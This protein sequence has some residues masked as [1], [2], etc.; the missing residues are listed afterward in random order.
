MSSTEDRFPDT[1]RLPREATAAPACLMGAGEACALA[2]AVDWSQTSIGPVD[3]W[4]QA[5]RST[6]SLV[7][8]N[9]SPMLLWWGADFVQIYNDAY[10]PVLGEK[11]PRAMG[12]RFR[13]C[14]S[15]VFHILGPMAERP[16][17][18]GPASVN[19][20][21]AVLIER[22]VPR[23]ETHF[24]LAYSPVPDASVESGIGGVLATVTETTEQIF[25]ERQL[26]TLR[27]LGAR[28]A[29]HADG[30]TAEQVCANA[31]A[32]FEDNAWDVPFAL[33]Y[34]LNE[35][36]TRARRAAS[37]GV[38]AQALE[39]LAPAQ[40][41]LANANADEP[42]PLREAVLERRIEIV[43]LLPQHADALPRSPWDEAT[44]S[45]IVL[46]LASSDRSRTFGV[47]ICGLSPHRV[48]DAGYRTFFELA[49]SQ[50]VTGIRDARALE[51][52]RKRAEALAAIDRAKTA[53]FS[54]VSH[55][56]RTP[57][58][59]M[60]GPVAEFA[61]DPSVPDQARAQLA[62]AHR[63]ALRLLRLVNTLLDFS[64]IEAGRVQ[65]SYEP[66]DL[67]ALTRNVAGTFRS[68]IERGGL[69]YTVECE[70]LAETVYVDPPMW[71]KIVLNLLSNAFKYTLRGEIAV[72]LRSRNAQALLEVS[73]TGAGIPDNELPRIFERF[74]RVEGVAGRTQEGTG[75]GLSLVQELVKLHGGEITAASEPGSGT[76]FVVS[77]PLGSTHLSADRLKP[78]H[79]GDPS[80]I[81]AQA[82]VQEAL[83]WIPESVV[84]EPAGPPDIVPDAVPVA[85]LP[86]IA[87]EDRLRVLVADDNADM[88]A[89]LRSLLAGRYAVEVVPDGAAALQAAARQRPDL[90]LADIMMPRLD[91]LGLLRAVRTDKQLLDIPVI[92][93]SARAGEEA[94]VDGLGAGADDY[95]VKPFSA[96][97]LVARIGALLELTALRRRSE[98]RFRALVNASSDAVYSV[99]ADW[100]E[101]RFLQGRDFIA[102][103]EGASSG[104]LE[105]YIAPEDRDA[106][107][108][109]IELAVRNKS[110]FE[111]EHRVRRVD[112][113]PGW[114]LSRAIP[115]L[116][117]HGEI[118]EW[119]GMAVDMTERKRVETVLRDTAAW[120][121]AQKEAFQAAV[122]NAPL[123]VSLDVLTKAAVRQMGARA[124]CAFY[125]A[126]AEQTELRHVTGMGAEYAASVESFR[127]AADSFSCGLAAYTR[128]PVITPDVTEDPSWK[129]WL[130]LAQQ[131]GYRGCW[132]FPV[133]TSAGKVVGTFAMYHEAPCKPTPLDRELAMRLA[134]TAAIIISH[135]Q[136]AEER[137]SGADALRVADRQKDEF[138]AMLAHELR[139]PLA[140][141]TNAGEL[142]SRMLTGDAE[143]QHAIDMIKRQTTQLSRLVDDLLDVSRITQGRIKLR[144]RAVDL[145]NVVAL[146]IETVEPQLRERQ[147]TLTVETAKRDE[148]L[149]VD[150]DMARLV[151]CVANVLS[152]AVKYTNPGGTI[153]VWTRPEGTHVVIGISDNGSGI[154]AELLP[155]VFDLFVQSERT[156]DRAQGGLG[157]GLAVARRLVEMH[158]GTISAQ[159]PGIGH[160][161]TFEIRLR[162][163]ARPAA[164]V[165]AAGAADVDQRRVLVVDDNKDG[166]DSL[167]AL[168]ALQGHTLAVAYSGP[169]AIRLA[170][171]FLPEIALLDIGLPGMSGYELAQTLRTMPQLAGLRLVAI[172]GYGQAEDFQRSRAAG[173]DYHLVKP[174][175]Q[176]ALQRALAALHHNWEN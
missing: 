18:G 75:I 131:H 23:E 17:R 32:V 163:I 65:A 150:G 121:A 136:E 99:S 119:F 115:V 96:R 21:I 138:L 73:D 59:L 80:A 169:E 8:H 171:A 71:E 175:D 130:W 161:A 78:A 152:N 63:N 105:R 162:R 44:R 90:I 125:L 158:Q 85:A 66:T 107:L 102:N 53:F 51:E 154:S 47:L 144:R 86:A 5:L 7:L 57:L 117:S 134:Q 168:L 103:T 22:K 38:S 109:H 39:H 14:W 147:H 170:A 54:N 9:H 42:W 133:E 120:V 49:A 68:A 153:R 62:L 149:Y 106:V 167:A 143:A 13:D 172:T 128:Q 50:V 151:Q 87:A 156:L 110:K 124:R 100:S 67:A 126:N 37:A 6:A 31:A 141:I 27:E 123:A 122:N 135:H 34:L 43:A 101:M 94:R 52:E 30:Q 70:T 72:R 155:H 41:E 112:G 97:E 15:E 64:R 45:A 74:H 2:R 16:F 145:A 142:L 132:S 148:P 48:V 118:V 92:L 25:V 60:L 160:G 3:G 20:D 61:S 10:R 19:D 93:L 26:R 114:T 84:D 137:A 98:E 69:T 35:D 165:A 95:L 29:A 33:L 89:Y 11:H 12:Q 157:I 129:E 104:W 111:L 146:G 24:R 40:V 88:R 36:G 77:I 4:S 164:P 166:A 28:G 113:T 91:G 46:P 83:R 1:Q 82:F 58:T 108:A 140:P 55:E 79:A 81:H 173:F 56:F 116:D 174:V 159:S 76:R 127:I 176:Q 139:N